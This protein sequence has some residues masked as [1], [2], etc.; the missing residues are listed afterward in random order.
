MKSLYDWGQMSGRS[1]SGSAAKAGGIHV[2]TKLSRLYSSIPLVAPPHCRMK[3][4]AIIMQLIM[5]LLWLL[6]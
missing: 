3:R 4:G 1:S 2:V 6:F 5:N